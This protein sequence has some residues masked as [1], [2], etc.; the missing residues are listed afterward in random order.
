MLV[1]KHL[2][3]IETK[4]GRDNAAFLDDDIEVGLG[5]RRR[6]RRLVGDVDAPLRVLVGAPF[7]AER[8]RRQDDIGVQEVRR[9]PVGFRDHDKHLLHCRAHKRTH[10]GHVDVSRKRKLDH[11]QATPQAA[12]HH[13]D[14]HTG[15]FLGRRFRQPRGL[16]APSFCDLVAVRRVVQAFVERKAPGKTAHEPF[17]HGVRLARHLKRARAGP[18]DVAGQQVQADD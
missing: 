18:R 4:P 9:V 11:L 16:D 17:R 15:V 12:L 1:R 13:A 7:F 8:G 6:L 2:V 5:V 10:L 14:G 3:G